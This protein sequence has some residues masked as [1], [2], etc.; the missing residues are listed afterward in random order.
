[1][2]S[3]NIGA[4]LKTLAS[5]SGYAWF[6]SEFSTADGPQFLPLRLEPLYLE[7]VA[8]VITKA[9]SAAHTYKEVLQWISL[10][11]H[12][13]WSVGLGLQGSYEQKSSMMSYAKDS[14]ESLSTLI[15][16]LNQKWHHDM[17]LESNW[18]PEAGEAS[19]EAVFKCDAGHWSAAEWET[20]EDL[21][22]ALVSGGLQRGYIMPAPSAEI[23]RFSR[24]PD[25][26]CSY[27]RP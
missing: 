9:L 2:D 13:L 16:C 10:A 14:L 18:T 27:F 11:Y 6:A 12:C 5:I 17:R 3:E 26:L 20:I 19:M 21:T 22:Q 25:G 8:D 1:M 23:K 4:I 15:T 7:E 24:D